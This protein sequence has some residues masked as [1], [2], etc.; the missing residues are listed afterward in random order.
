MST[1]NLCFGEKLRKI[2]TPVSYT[3]VACKEVFISLTYFFLL[4]VWVEAWEEV[5]WEAVEIWEVAWAE[6]WEEGWEAAWAE[7]VAWG[8][9]I[10]REL[11]S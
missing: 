8:K 11:I 9:L 4:Q 6:L 7:A 3:E 10:Y 1:H 2:Y 5:V